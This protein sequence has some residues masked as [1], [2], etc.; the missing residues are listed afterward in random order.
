MSCINKITTIISMSTISVGGVA[1]E[2][3]ATGWQST[4]EA[5]VV[6]TNGNTRTS[7]FNGKF[8]TNKEVDK[9]R[10]N[11]HAEA[12]SSSNNNI[13]SAEKYLASGQS[14]YKFN[15]FD[16]MYGL[17]MHEKDRFSGYDYQTTLAL[18]YGRRLINDEMMKLDLEIGPG[19][20]F[21][22]VDASIDPNAK[23]KGDALLRIAAKYLWK[24]S[25]TATF[26]EDL[27]SE[28]GGDA[29][30]TKSITGLKANI[31]SSLAMKAT[32]TVKHTS[33]VPV[34]TKKTDTE[35]ALTL[36]YSF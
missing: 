4:A 24:V 23:T 2:A 3:P 1:A 32:V 27:T 25:Q 28:V 12:L 30:I 33:A 35:T 6:V 26:T 31:N 21:S 5:G 20:R 29:N 22:R 15:K 14:N 36:V 19:V 8:D 7:T 11:I 34:G 10:Y 18:G 17:A 9:W 13:Q 16:Y